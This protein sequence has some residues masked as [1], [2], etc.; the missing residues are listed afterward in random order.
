MV[1]SPA[2]RQNVKTVPFDVVTSC[3]YVI[4]NT[5]RVIMFRKD[6][7]MFRFPVVK[8]SLR[9]PTVK[10]IAVPVTSCINDFG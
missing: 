9:F 2:G 6:L 5:R 3:F 10:I 7:E 8:S 1:V 4:S